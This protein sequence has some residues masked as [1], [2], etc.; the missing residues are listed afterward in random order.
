M[1]TSD[2]LANWLDERAN[3]PGRR[4]YL[5][6]KDCDKLRESALRV[7]NCAS[8]HDGD[9]EEDCDAVSTPTVGGMSSCGRG[10]VLPLGHKADH[11]IQQLGNDGTGTHPKEP[12]SDG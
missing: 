3:C 7:R 9:R 11:Q 2:E 10:C 1:I 6:K 8:W 12:E 5:S 4:V